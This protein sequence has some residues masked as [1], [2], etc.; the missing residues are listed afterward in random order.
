MDDQSVIQMDNYFDDWLIG[1]LG[2]RLD[3]KYMPKFVV[4]I[5]P[6]SKLCR[7]SRYDNCIER[8]HQNLAAKW[9]N[10]LRNFSEL[11]LIEGT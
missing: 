5:L 2:S 6:Q 4:N 1:C 7:K 11:F 10:W 9:I 8:D 3:E